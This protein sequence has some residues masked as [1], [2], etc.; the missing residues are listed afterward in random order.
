MAK[1]P[2]LLMFGRHVGDIA[3]HQRKKQEKVLKGDTK[4]FK[5]SAK[6]FFK[7]R[8][9]AEGRR[10]V[11]I[12]ELS[13]DIDADKLKDDKGRKLDKEEVLKEK[14]KPKESLLDQIEGMLDEATEDLLAIFSLTLNI[15]EKMF[16]FSDWGYEP[17]MIAINRKYPGRIA[18]ILEPQTAE[19]LIQM[20]E[21]ELLCK[22]IMEAGIN[23]NMDKLIQ[24]KLEEQRIML[25]S[26]LQRDEQIF[27]L[28]KRLAQ[29][30][31][32]RAI[33]IPRGGAHSAMAQRFFANSDLFD[34]EC[35]VSSEESGFGE[36]E[37][38]RAY[39][40]GIETVTMEE[41]E[42]IARLNLHWSRYKSEHIES[43]G[44]ELLCRVGASDFAYRRMVR[45][46]REYALA[47]ESQ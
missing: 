26:L 41:R 10:G 31:P 9:L 35:H 15:G 44:F 33:I 29:E 12:H 42:R 24:M 36:E 38:I 19:A 27:K 3:K 21:E 32:E 2:L 6:K 37:L 23:E 13:I 5:R 16:S 17:Q 46:A 14:D 8:I 28:A 7:D 25:E 11:V 43:V 18:N 39:C 4:F 47:I 40:N 30:D 1:T 34:I 22:R 20:W 45:K